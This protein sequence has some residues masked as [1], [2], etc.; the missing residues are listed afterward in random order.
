MKLETLENIVE[1]IRKRFKNPK[2]SNSNCA[3]VCRHTSDALCRCLIISL[4]LVTPGQTE[5]S[6]E[7]HENKPSDGAIENSQVLWIDLRIEELWSSSIE[8]SAD[9][10]ILETKWTPKLSSIRNIRVKK[11]SDKDMSS[12]NLLL[13]AAFNFFRDTSSVMVPS[14][15]KMYSIP[16]RFAIDMQM[17]PEIDRIE[18]RDLSIQKKL[19]IWAYTLLHGQYTSIGSIIRYCEENIK[20]S[21]SCPVYA[22]ISS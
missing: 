19:L 21:F 17:K 5:A 13:R 3:K 7:V 10:K 15:V 4:A 2:L 22:V 8:N 18:I 9:L 16:S 12:V 20:V 6:S 1:K 11:V 14:G